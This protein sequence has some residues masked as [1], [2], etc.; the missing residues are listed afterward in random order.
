MVEDLCKVILFGKTTKIIE[1]CYMMNLIHCEH[2]NGSSY[3]SDEDLMRTWKV[4]VG[5][6]V[7]AYITFAPKITMEDQLYNEY[8]FIRKGSPIRFANPFEQ[9]RM[10][11]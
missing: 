8:L 10:F 6:I 4:G 1:F 9:K 3:P 11:L 7:M 5:V 2:N